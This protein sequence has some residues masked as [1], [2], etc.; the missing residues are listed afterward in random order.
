MVG[1]HPHGDPYFPNQ[2]NVG[3]IEAEPEDDHPIPLDYHLVEGFSEDSDS[4]PEINNL[5][6]VAQI[7]NANPRPAFQGPTPLWET[8][9]NR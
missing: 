3:W 8:N 9:L 7:P 5:P 1:Y 2:G 6:Q 4:E